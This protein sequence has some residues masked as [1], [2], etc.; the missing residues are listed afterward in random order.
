LLNHGT[1]AGTAA[2]AGLPDAFD[3]DVTW[4]PERDGAVTRN[5]AQRLH[6]T[7]ILEITRG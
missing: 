4:P 6:R 3:P 5:A 2:I 1:L 7:V